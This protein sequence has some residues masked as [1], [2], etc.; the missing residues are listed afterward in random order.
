MKLLIVCLLFQNPEV[1]QCVLESD[2]PCKQLFLKQSYWESNYHRFPIAIKK[3]N[4]SGFRKKING[5]YQMITFKSIE[6][7]V[8]YS[9][10]FFKRKKITNCK[11]YERYILKGK[12]SK[13]GNHKKYLKQIKKIN[14]K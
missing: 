7:Y 5:K 4:Y 14:G 3:N 8:N 6:E 11:E 12:Y 9:S 1:V 2:I 10:E 13:T